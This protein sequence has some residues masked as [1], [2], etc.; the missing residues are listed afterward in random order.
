[1]TLKARRIMRTIFL[2][3]FLIATPLVS[4]YAAGYKFSLQKGGLQKTGMLILDTEPQGARIYLNGVPQQTA[5]KKLVNEVFRNTD[6]AIHL[7]S[8]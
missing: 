5:I 1:M 7:A 4:L 8:G 6:P 2:L 3:A